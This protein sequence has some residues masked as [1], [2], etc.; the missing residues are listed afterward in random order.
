MTVAQQGT[1]GKTSGS[2]MGRISGPEE[3]LARFRGRGHVIDMIDQRPAS[4]P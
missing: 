2:G 1:F 3:W 4:S